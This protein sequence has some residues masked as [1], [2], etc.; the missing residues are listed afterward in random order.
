M[1]D[2]KG[3][4]DI[5][6]KL[7]GLEDSSSQ[8]NILLD[9]IKETINSNEEF[10]K[11]LTGIINDEEDL[12]KAAPRL[13][14]VLKDWKVC[15][16]CTSFSSCP[17][18]SARGN[19]LALIKNGEDFEIKTCICQK[20]Q[21]AMKY[22]K[23]LVHVDCDPYLIFI[24]SGK[25]GKIPNVKS[26]STFFQA[27]KIINSLTTSQDLYADKGII[28]VS[29]NDNRKFLAYHTCLQGIVHEKRTSYFDAKV[30]FNDFNA[31][32]Y[33]K[34]IKEIESSKLIIFDN[35]DRS[36]FTYQFLKEYLPKLLLAA[37][38]SN[39]TLIIFSSSPII[40]LV[41]IYRSCPQAKNIL[42][43]FLKHT[44]TD[45]LLFKI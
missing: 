17:K 3:L 7:N 41:D 14:K 28:I 2:F 24:P 20:K 8:L 40:P 34:C 15:S 5:D 18:K 38:S 29:E 9:D 12:S 39:R 30:S 21:N 31:D 4:T 22:T 37:T 1:A 35:F 25:L 16:S 6:L 43:K 13:F 19:I 42:S 45:P 36:S 10:K 32:D 11:R 26:P 44:V 33:S 27:V 23:N